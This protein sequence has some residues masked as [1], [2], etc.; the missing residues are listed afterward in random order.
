MKLLKILL[1]FVVM[2]VP[3][4]A[5]AQFGTLRGNPVANGSSANGTT[6]VWLGDSFG[7]GI[8]VGPVAVG[9]T[10]NTYWPLLFGGIDA[11]NNAQFIPLGSLNQVRV[12][13]EAASKAVT[14]FSSATATSTGTTNSTAVTGLGIYKQIQILCN[15]TAAATVSG[16][17]LDVYVDTSPD[18]GT[19]WLNA[20]HFT[21]VL[22]NGGVKAFWATLDPGGAPAATVTAVTTDA[23]SGVVRPSMFTDTLRVRY[24]IVSG[25][26]PSFTFSVL[27]FCKN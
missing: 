7:N 16:D 9:S 3:I 13:N 8:V 24:V 14:L 4:S 1:A 10:G 22:G 27:A 11:S 5:H 15:V 17:T 18:S 25:S 21:Q 26:A 12:Q 6:H 19:T 2:L 20:V 23:S